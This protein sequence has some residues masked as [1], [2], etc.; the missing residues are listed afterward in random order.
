MS[1][2][3]RLD[4]VVTH[5]LDGFRS[6]VARFNEILAGRLGV[7]LLGLFDDRVQNLTTPLLSFKI[8]EL[9]ADEAERFEQVT[10]R[11]SWQPELYLHEFSDLP[12]ERRLVAAAEFVYCGNALIAEHVAAVTSSYDTVWSPGLLLDDRIFEPAELSVF[13]FGMAHKI[14][15]SMYRRLRKLLDASGSPYAVYVSAAN[16]E[17]ASLRDAEVVFQ[18]MHEIFPTGL[19]FL[20]NLSDVAVF[21]QL[22]DT[23]FYAAFFDGGVRA[24]NSSVGSALERGAVVLTNLDQWSPP[25]YKHMENLIDINRCESLPHDP[26]VLERLSMHAVETA[27]SRS[28]E[29]LVERLGTLG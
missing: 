20:G 2:S 3:E 6:G 7:P 11:A 27:R 19:Y 15:T 24:N 22:R 13:S 21:N 14:Q 17:T 10:Q 29:K 12:L 25:E 16:H 8:S 1:V 5:H 9:S 18:E 4:A 23:T 28:W 26:A